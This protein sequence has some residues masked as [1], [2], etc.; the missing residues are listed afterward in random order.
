MYLWRQS[1]A[2]W[3]QLKMTMIENECLTAWRWSFAK[4]QQ[5]T[6]RRVIG[7]IRKHWGFLGDVGGV[8]AVGGVMGVWGAGKECR[9]WETRKVYVAYRGIGGLLWV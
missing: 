4:W 1:V 2:K 6:T 5:L 8:G 7:G 3:Q 9:Y